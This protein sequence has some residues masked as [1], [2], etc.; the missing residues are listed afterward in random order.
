MV[1]RE[2]VRR[3]LAALDRYRRHLARL[4]D[5][6]PQTY[7]AEETFAGRY[8]V[9]AAAQTCIDLAN[10]V[11]SSER[12]RVPTDYRDAFTVLEERGAI[13]ADLAT[14]LR[15]LAGLRN[16]L[17][18]LYEEVDDRLVH[19]YLRDRLADLDLLA[20]AMAS[21]VATADGDQAR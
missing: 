20:A 11:I 1:D 17:V 2:R 5:L 21:L 3:L 7:L 6:P 15:A 4:R 14:R 12:W 9:Q 18:H 13:E 19:E 16:R 10:H 8:L